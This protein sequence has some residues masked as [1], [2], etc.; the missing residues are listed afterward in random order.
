M[1]AA[2]VPIGGTLAAAKKLEGK[3]GLDLTSQP[4]E[5]EAIAKL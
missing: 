1:A 2:D 4:T 5:G 3:L